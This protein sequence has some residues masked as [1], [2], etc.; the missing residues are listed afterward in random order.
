LN[1]IG[2]FFHV[3]SEFVNLIAKHSIYYSLANFT[4]AG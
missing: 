3:I 2:H 1:L 4:L